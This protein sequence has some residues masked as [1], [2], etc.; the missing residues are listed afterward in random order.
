MSVSY[1]VNNS[2]FLFAREVTKFILHPVYKYFNLK[3]F[4][5]HLVYWDVYRNIFDDLNPT[6][7]AQ[8]LIAPFEF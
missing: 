4:Y 2:I 3:R 6:K 7:S 1:A 5:R 8:F